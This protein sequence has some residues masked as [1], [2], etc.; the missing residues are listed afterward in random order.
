ML[1]QLELERYFTRAEAEVAAIHLDHRSAANM[2]TNQ[3]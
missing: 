3:R 1:Q 2:R